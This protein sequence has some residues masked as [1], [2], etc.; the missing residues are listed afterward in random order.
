MNRWVE[1]MSNI[2]F[3]AMP[4]E[5]T[6]PLGL[7]IKKK[8][9]QLGYKNAVAMGLANAPSNNAILTGGA[10]TVAHVIAGLALPVENQ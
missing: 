5:F 2:A 1:H 4:G 7:R 6:A 10:A 8:V 3:L 9:V